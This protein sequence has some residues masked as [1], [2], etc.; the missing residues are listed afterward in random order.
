[1]LTSP[2]FDAFIHLRYMLYIPLNKSGKVPEVL[3]F[4]RLFLELNRLICN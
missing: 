1:M 4:D 3:N 2:G